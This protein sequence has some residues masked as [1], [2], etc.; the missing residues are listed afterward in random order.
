M[1]ARRAR[2]GAGLV[3]PRLLSEVSQAGA[4]SPA[5]EP[6]G[7]QIPAGLEAR[8]EI[9]MAR[10]IRAHCLA[11]GQSAAQIALIIHSQCSPAFGTTLV[12]AHRLALG[13]ALADVV[14]QVRA[15]YV[16]EGRTAPRFSETLLSSYEG[17]QK[18]PGPEYLHYL[19]CVYQAEPAD[20]G[21]EGPCLCGQGHRAPPL[22]P[23]GPVH[24]APPDPG[25]P[26]G[27]G[28]HG[29]DLPGAPRSTPPLLTAVP[30]RGEP[31]P[32]EPG[33][34]TAGGPVGLTATQL[35]APE[36]GCVGRLAAASPATA[37]G[38]A[39]SASVLAAS[40]LPA[41]ATV[42]A[43]ALPASALPASALPPSALPPASATLPGSVP[44][45]SPRPATAGLVPGPAIGGAAQAADPAA[46]SVGEMDDDMVR[47]TLLRLMADPGAPADGRFLG[48]VERIRRRLDEALLGSTVSVA[49]LDHWEGMTGE[50][51]R[52][53][54]TVPPMRLL[55]DVLLDLGDVRRMCEQRQPLEFVERLCRL[56][57]R[58]AGL[59]GMTM[60]DVGDHRVARSF[61]STARTAADETGDRHLRAW[62]AV[63]ESLVPLY[64]GDPAQ[65]A[66]AA[67]A[68]ADL[69]GHQ[70]CVAGVMAPV[71]EA[72]ALARLA[73]ARACGGVPGTVG[74][75]GGAGGAEVR[76]ASAALDQAHEALDR[77]PE[78]DRR[79]T[80]FG[81][82]ERQLLFHQGDAL[83]T[84]G[85]CRGADDAFGQAMRLYSP[86]EFLDR[87]LVTLGRARCRLEAGE[88]E[89]ALRLSR[90]TLLGLPS[91]HRP[92]IVL[93]AARSLGEAVAAK[94]GDFP[95]VRDYR[96]VLV[97]R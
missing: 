6:G 48:A 85:D 38:P 35:P 89:E 37:T 57:A 55:C 67:R 78:D 22:V 77:L 86:A 45:A 53:Y 5:L 74:G 28:L 68:S 32:A 50:Y 2:S 90:D 46:L 18:R 17:G 82:T 64:Y 63:R 88:P 34:R 15:R 65:A 58:L 59:A 40:A 80:V 71:V 54:M 75:R 21:Y 23:S 93:R 36:P 16:R 49:M 1:G 60:I 84:L 31:G 27:P 66:A 51:G 47:R 8:Q 41:P 91:Q 61:F 83:V 76:R 39:R 10:A 52:Q 94:H 4:G 24:A 7:T 87:S 20:L 25:R 26:D 33:G 29:Y 73:R 9:S 44:V 12:R 96:E 95:A 69:A 62:V 97:S 19:C 43:P 56:A 3:A 11:S 14:A 81:Y 42:P 79:D 92:G 13:I 30:G 70:P 72:R